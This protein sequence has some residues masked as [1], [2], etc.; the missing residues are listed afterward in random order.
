MTVSEST[1]L[2]ALQ[3]VVDPNTGQDFVSTRQLKQLRIDGG[4]VRFEVEL[5]YP[6]LSQLDAP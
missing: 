3:A 1:L 2:S 5:G 6:A 4:T